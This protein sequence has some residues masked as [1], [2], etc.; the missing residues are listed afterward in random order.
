MAEVQNR[1]RQLTDLFPG[2]LSQA[3]ESSRISQAAYREGGSDLLRLLDTERVR[4]EA[5]LMY[6]R[7]LAEYRQSLATLDAASGV[8]P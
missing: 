7:T 3:N 6:Y 8:A 4:I 1:R 2:I 5:Q